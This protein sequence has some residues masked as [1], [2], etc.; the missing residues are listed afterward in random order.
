MNI[1]LFENG[2]GGALAKN[3]ERAVH[4]IKVLHKKVGDEFDA[5]ILDGP[6]GTGRIERVDSDGTVNVSF[7]PDGAVP[8]ARLPLAVAVGFPRPIQLRRILRDL[9]S[10]GVREIVLFATDLG[11]KSYRDTTLFDSGGA[12]RALIDGAAQ[13]RD[14]TLPRLSLFPSLNAWLSSLPSE[15]ASFRVAADNVNA[16]GDFT[17]VPP[18]AR[19]FTL[20]VGSERGWSNRERALFHAAGF[21]RFSLGS[22][23]LRTETACAVCAAVLTMF[24]ERKPV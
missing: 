16:A 19:A 6:R 24:I 17:A 5:G 11:E 13:S 8:P 9:S 4:I 1:I 2:E 14:T 10:I 21:T 22:R 7:T 18:D 20:A 23:A 15:D 3:D 12:R